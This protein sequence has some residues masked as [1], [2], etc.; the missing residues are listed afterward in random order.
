MAALTLTGSA[1]RGGRAVSSKIFSWC[2]KRGK[3]VYEPFLY[4]SWPRLW[5]LLTELVLG[6]VANS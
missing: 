1:A 2:L 6:A 5:V 3:Q 4:E